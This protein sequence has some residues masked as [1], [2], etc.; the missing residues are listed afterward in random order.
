MLGPLIVGLVTGE[1]GSAI[2]RARRAAIAYA[3][4]GLL[5]FMGLVFLLLA[6]WIYAARKIG[7]IE[8]ALWF[9]GIFLVLAAATVITHRLVARARARTAARQR[10]RDLAAV[11]ATTAV[12]SV[13]VLTRSRGGLGA[14]AV[15]IAALG[16]Y[17]LYRLLRDND[18]S[19]GGGRPGR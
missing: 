6:A 7:P 17:A 15:G 18:D 5:V 3:A 11:A 12:A 8:A 10:T 13:P 9:G 4:A 16:G 1:A 19:E 2:R 14:L